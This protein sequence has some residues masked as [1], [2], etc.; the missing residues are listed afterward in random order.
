[1]SVED[2]VPD[3]GI[4]TRRRKLKL[5]GVLVA[6][7]E[8]V[9]N[10]RIGQ[11]A[12]WSLTLKVAYTGLTFIATMLLARLLGAAGYGVYA[13]VYSLITVLSIPSQFG[14]PPLVLRETAKG[15]ARN[16][17][18]LVRGIWVWSGRFVALASL[19]L[20]LVGGVGA[21]IWRARF[22]GVY[23]TTFAWALLLVPLVALGN[24]RGA[25]LRGLR[26]VVQGQLPE[27]LIQPCAL[28]VLLA[29]VLLLG[30]S[31]SPA[32]AMACQVAAAAVAFGVGAWL[33]VRATPAE[34]RQIRPRFEGHLWLRSVLPLALIGAMRLI[35]KNASVLILGL[36]VPPDQIGIYRLAVQIS[37]LASLGL[38]AMNMVVAPRFA[39]LY[40]RRD[41]ERLQRLVTSSARAILGFNLLVTL[42]FA[43][44]GR[45]FLRV[46]FGTEFVAAYLPLMILLVGQFVNSAVGSVGVLLNMTGHEQDAA[47]GMLV[48]AVV[49]V[50]L[51]LL[52]V[53]LA[54]VAGA[55]VGTGGGLITGNVLLWWM[56]RRRLGINSLAFSSLK[57]GRSRVL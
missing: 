55:A 10:S 19:G 51:N 22:H 1:M 6:R 25:A 24:L 50:L 47:W 35:N 54:G 7:V 44:L 23:L 43:L 29:I 5:P 42:G 16:E 15:I 39:G 48:S 38:L 18:A 33:L 4:K 27:N 32:Q 3:V 57:T 30:Y 31:P 26:L 53:P 17:P 56:V 49:G 52:L 13:Y 9:A 37:V 20:V 14:L 36:F 11:E 8:R 41:T 2:A 45:W 21:W 12:F 28:T 34:V 40:A 46:F